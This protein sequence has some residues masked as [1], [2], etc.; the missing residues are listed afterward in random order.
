MV[1][2][3]HDEDGLSQEIFTA[4]DDYLAGQQHKVALAAYYIAEKRGSSPGQELNDWLEAEHI[5]LGPSQK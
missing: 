4:Q 1:S 5:I 3:K 2:K